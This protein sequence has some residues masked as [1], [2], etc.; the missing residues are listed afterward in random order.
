M[1]KGDWYRV[2][3]DPRIPNH[4]L[5]S[6][7]DMKFHGQMRRKLSNLFAMTSIKSYEPYVDDCVPL[8]F[9]N[10][11]RFAASGE[12]VNLQ[13]W[14]QCYAFDVIGEITVSGSRGLIGSETIILTIVRR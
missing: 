3:G 5:F 8:V 4:N 12:V 13:Y 11:D 9:E 7:Q 14:L 1:P 10:F 2:W 6:A